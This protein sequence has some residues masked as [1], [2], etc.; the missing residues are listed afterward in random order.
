MVK[1]R[2]YPT[3]IALV[4]NFVT[5]EHKISL[6]FLYFWDWVPDNLKGLIFSLLNAYATHTFIGGEHEIFKTKKPQAMD[7]S[8]LLFWPNI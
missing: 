4:K 2:V 5:I 6:I 8:V 1:P 7:R 3:Y